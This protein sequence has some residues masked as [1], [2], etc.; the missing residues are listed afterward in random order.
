MNSSKNTRIQGLKILIAERDVN[1]RELIID[2]IKTSIDPYADVDFA[3]SADEAYV[4][5][6]AEDYDL[7]LTGHDLAGERDG[8]WLWETCH[9][10]FPNLATILISGPSLEIAI[11]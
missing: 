6:H 5:L 1:F 11:Q 8:V 2:M 3:E 4:R 10:T 7:L 9:D